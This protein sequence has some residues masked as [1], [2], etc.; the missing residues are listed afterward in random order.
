MMMMKRCPIPQVY[1]LDVDSFIEIRKSPLLK[2][3][4]I[5]IAS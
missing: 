4:E 5:W 1:H 2:Y 3:L